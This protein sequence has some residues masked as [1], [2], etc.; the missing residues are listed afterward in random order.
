MS[1]LPQPSRKTPVDVRARIQQYQKPASSEER[2]S[3]TKSNS[4]ND[5]Q[6]L[7]T[8][9][10]TIDSRESWLRIS[11]IDTIKPSPHSPGQHTPPKPPARRKKFQPMEL[12]KQPYVKSP[13]R[14]PDP[15]TTS[16]TSAPKK[17]GSTELS[18]LPPAPQ[19]H[20]R[21]QKTQTLRTPPRPPPPSTKPPI[22]KAATIDEGRD[23]PP[24]PSPMA[25]QPSPKSKPSNNVQLSPKPRRTK[26]ALEIAK[27]S[28]SP[29]RERKSSGN[30][31]SLSDSNEE[32]K[33]GESGLQYLHSYMEFLPVCNEYLIYLPIQQ[34]DV[35]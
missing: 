23:H 11:V 20:P 18:I 28:H 33:K 8:Q 26:P 12:P 4:F 6:S 30:S 31:S 3:I 21:I 14:T 7:R 10:K 9:Y 34:S 1:E 24:P 22:V 15:P 35:D 5:L 19:P 27:P 13:E 25:T 2:S 32:E 29:T 16:E 17:L